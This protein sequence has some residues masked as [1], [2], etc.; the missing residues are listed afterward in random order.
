[1]Q[2]H[3]KQTKNT[4]TTPP[5]TRQSSKTR[6]LTQTTIQECKMTPPPLVRTSTP[7]QASTSEASNS[8]FLYEDS[9]PI[10]NQE[11]LITLIPYSQK[12]QTM[13]AEPSKSETQ[14]L[15]NAMDVDPL[16]DSVT[17]INLSGIL[18]KS[19]QLQPEAQIETPV[20]ERLALTQTTNFIEVRGKRLRAALTI[21][22]KASHH[23]A[24][25]ETCPHEKFTTQKHVPL[26]PTTHLPHQ[27]RC[28]KA[29][30]G[31]PPPSLT[32][33]YNHIGTALCECDQRGTGD[34]RENKARDDRISH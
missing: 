9:T 28:G 4:R 31:H 26:G 14:L 1:M 8:Q 18:N 15:D 7:T 16:S 5:I 19:I 21:I 17:H 10:N 25:M 12:N 24:F 34:P 27:S 20:D 22:A 11:Q 29:V 30:E 2:H 13:A 6:T 23:K 33:S 3:S 32:Q